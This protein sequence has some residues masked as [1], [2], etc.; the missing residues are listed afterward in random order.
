[1][2]DYQER[3]QMDRY[4]I[5]NPDAQ[6]KVGDTVVVAMKRKFQ[7]D[8]EVIE[9]REVGVVSRVWT[10]S[11]GAEV[12]YSVALR[13][14]S[15]PKEAWEIVEH[16]GR[17]QL[18]VLV[19]TSYAEICRRVST[20]IIELEPENQ[21]FSDAV[22]TAMVNEEFVPAG[23]ILSGVGRANL[24]L[25]LFNCHVYPPPHDSREGIA[26]HWKLIFD[27]FSTG[28]GVGWHCSSLRPKGAIVRKVNGR[29]SGVVS[30]ME[31]FS[32]IT[33]VV[34]Q[35]GSRRGA[36]L[37]SLWIW[38]PDI[39]DFI[40]AKS[41]KTSFTLEDGR[42]VTRNLDLIKNSNVSV[43]LSDKFMEAVKQDALWDLVFPDLDDPDYDNV[44]KGDLE[45]WQALGKKTVVYRRVKAK[46]LWELII[47][48]A[49]ESGEPG[50]LFMDRANKLSNSWYYDKISCGNPCAEA[51][52][53]IYGVCNLGHLHLAK[54][55]RPGVEQF[56]EHESDSESAIK[57]V[58]WEKFRAVIQ[59]AIRFLD[60]I[61][62]IN[63]Y[64]LTE[65]ELQQKKERRIGLGVLGFAELLVRLGLRIAT[66]RRWTWLRNGG[67]FQLLIVRSSWLLVS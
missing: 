44:W 27:T 60:N 5:K 59:L 41:Q 46:W 14:N 16:L 56:P 55:L 7:Q 21:L 4:A 8:G 29:S 15:L 62:D 39:I 35:G 17:T 58:D 61:T 33:G 40:E 30:W 1:M 26:K 64:Q 45:E 12:E 42:V 48:K 37:Q 50:L 31:Q 34:E 13:N 19:E 23:R 9:S 22:C 67:H 2:Q 25:T 49:W 28:G 66:L 43:L 54:F 63:K 53:P 10:A 11:G 3:I 51:M 24:N 20:G 57:K 6:P 36:S 47:Q 52:L 18:D 32:Q 38:H 65:S